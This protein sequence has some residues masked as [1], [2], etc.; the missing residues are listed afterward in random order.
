MQMSLVCQEW[1]IPHINLAD[2]KNL[3]E[4]SQKIEELEN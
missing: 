2:I 4:I 1:G 3:D